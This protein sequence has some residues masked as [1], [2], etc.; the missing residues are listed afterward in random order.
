MLVAAG[1]PLLD[2]ALGAPVAFLVPLGV[3]LLAYSGALM[4]LAREGAPSPG[5]E[6]VIIGNALWVGASGVVVVADWLTLT[7]TGTVIALLQAAA[8]AVLA[9]LQFLALRRIPRSKEL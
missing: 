5:V 7:A 3:F 8:V 4:L 9:D 6:A 2:H 1:A